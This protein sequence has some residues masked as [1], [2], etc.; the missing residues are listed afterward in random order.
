MN[1]CQKGKRG[2]REAAEWLRDR[3]I[4]A[5]RGCQFSGSADS[6]DVVSDLPG[7]H[8]EVKRTESLRLYPSLDQA[9]ADAGGAVPVVL[10]RPNRRRWIA[11]LDG[12]DFLKLARKASGAALTAGDDPAEGRATA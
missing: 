3:G 1:S 7:F 11:V 8:L 9:T 12:E 5:R 4:S 10:H 2:E 6:P